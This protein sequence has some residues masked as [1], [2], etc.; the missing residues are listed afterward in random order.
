M[1]HHH[2]HQI[3]INIKHAA[4][5]SQLSNKRANI[6]IVNYVLHENSHAELQMDQPFHAHEM[7]IH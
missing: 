6:N 3:G 5:V 1:Y 2:N 7:M 4:L